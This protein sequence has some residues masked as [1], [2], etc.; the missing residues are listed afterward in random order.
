[1]AHLRSGFGNLPPQSR[2]LIQVNDVA[3][4]TNGNLWRASSTMVVEA[5]PLYAD[6]TADLVVIGGCFTGNAAA[7]EAARRGASVVLLEAETFGHGGSGPNVGLVNAGLWLPPLEVMKQ[8][9]QEAGLRLVN[10]L[11][12]APKL[13]W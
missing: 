8:I 7:L 1:A 13:V 4:N 11:A 12:E 10:I 9:G 5:P 6:T 2:V 3:K